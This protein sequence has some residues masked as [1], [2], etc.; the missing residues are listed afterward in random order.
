MRAKIISTIFVPS[1]GVAWYVIV[2]NNS[3]FLRGQT[4]VEFFT[5]LSLV[6]VFV[7]GL[8]IGGIWFIKWIWE[9]K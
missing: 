8:S 2:I 9:D 4:G 3:P 1:L 6:L 5:V 7:S